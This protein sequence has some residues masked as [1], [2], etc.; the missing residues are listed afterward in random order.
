MANFKCELLMNLLLT[1]GKSYL[2][3]TNLLFGEIMGLVM[4]P[5]DLPDDNFYN[6]YENGLAC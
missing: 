4:K 6:T 1:I 2:T 5:L 3:C